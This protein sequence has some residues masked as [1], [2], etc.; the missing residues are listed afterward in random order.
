MYIFWVFF[1][2]LIKLAA[3]IDKLL[4]SWFVLFLKMSYILYLHDFWKTSFDEKIPTKH[5][6]LKCHFISLTFSGTRV[7]QLALS[8]PNNRAQN[9]VNCLKSIPPKEG[10]CCSMCVFFFLF[11]FKILMFFSFGYFVIN[12]I[13]PRRHLLG[14][15]VLLWARLLSF[16]SCWVLRDVQG[17]PLSVLYSIFIDVQNSLFTIQKTESA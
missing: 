7:K 15:E 8:N 5:I 17:T 1:L 11:F 4:W 12:I 3:V 9:R 13:P 2:C 14:Q 6:T 16:S 10:N